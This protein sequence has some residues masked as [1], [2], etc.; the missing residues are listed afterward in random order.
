M[1]HFDLGSHTRAVS[2]V[3]PD[4]QRLFN[5]GLNWCFGFNQEEGVTCFKEVLKYDPN[6]VMAHWGIA[7]AR[8]PF[9]NNLWRQHCP[10]E[11]ADT[12]RI[13]Y[14]HI[15]AARAAFDY[16]ND[17][18]KELVEALSARFQQ[19]HPVS[20]NEFD[21]WDDDYANACLLYTSPSPRD[22]RQSRMPSSA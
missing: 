6:C 17:L 20:P 13:C 18:E 2:T 12:T 11:A 10:Q 21:R 5:L 22:K 3:S 7:Y 1:E 19:P 16:A 8:G 15:Q 9:Y 4:A 14:E